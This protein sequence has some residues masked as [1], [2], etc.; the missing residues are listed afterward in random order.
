MKKKFLPLFIGAISI[1]HNINS[2]A[3]TGNWKLSGNNLT[4]TEKLGSLNNLD[5]RI[6][7]DNVTRM[8]IKGNTGN[9]FV[10]IGT[11]APG[12]K[13]HI[14]SGTG[15]AGFLV[16]INDVTKLYV[17]GNGGVSVGSPHL[18][19]SN[20]LFVNGNIGVGTNTPSRELDVVHGGP[21]GSSAGLRLRNAGS[22]NQDWTFY[23]SDGSGN[24]LLYE[25]NNLKGQF[26]DASGAYTSVSDKRFKKDIEKAPDVVEKIMQLEVKKFHFLKNKPEDKKYYGMIAQEVEGIFPEIVTHSMGDDSKDFYTMDYSAVG[27]LA[28]KAIQEQQ[29]KISSL[30]SRI[31]ELE[32]RLNTGNVI[33]SNDN[34]S[35]EVIN[36]ISLE[37]NIPNPFSKTTTIGYSLPQKFTHAQIV[38]ADKNGKTLKQINI[39]GG[40]KGIINV[41]VA[42]LSAGIY[43]YSLIIDGRMINSKQM[44]LAK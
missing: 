26:D 35:N 4:G 6:I 43:Y 34:I 40:G 25:N 15:Q 37:Q 23:T 22:N 44:V 8:T 24:L 20:G 19:P 9:G 36:S 11:T 30:E 10:G 5:L 33:N 16:K 14:N 39:S 2:N 28:I 38:I 13:L 32:T 21:N 1:C 41:N 42:E 29:K 27:V 7:T 31:A 12:A 18:P 17:A 3:Q